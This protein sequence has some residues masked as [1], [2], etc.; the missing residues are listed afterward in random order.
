MPDGSEHRQR[1]RVP[2]GS[3]KK[4]AKQWGEALERHWYRELTR[5]YG[6]CR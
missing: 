3:T 5:G 4:E 6:M 1:R 2:V